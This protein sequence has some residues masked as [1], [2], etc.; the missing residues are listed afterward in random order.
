MR[1]NICVCVCVC[2]CVCKD[3]PIRENKNWGLSMNA[4]RSTY[5][6]TIENWLLKLEREKRITKD[7]RKNY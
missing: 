4:N 7:I 5:E 1:V 3:D 6:W 2:V